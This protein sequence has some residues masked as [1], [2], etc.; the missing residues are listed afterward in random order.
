MGKKKQYRKLKLIASTLPAKDL[1]NAEVIMSKG[2]A[3]KLKIDTSKL[4]EGKGMMVL[5]KFKENHYRKLKKEYVK[6]GLKKAWEH[7]EKMKPAEEIK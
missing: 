1:G 3:E 2:A 5:G 4:E 6:G 7:Y